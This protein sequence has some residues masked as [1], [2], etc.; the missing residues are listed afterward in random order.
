MKIKDFGLAKGDWIVHP[1]HGVGKVR[2]L[3]QKT[4]DGEPQPYLRVEGSKY[5]WWIAIDQIDENPIRPLRKPSTFKRALR[6]LKEEP[7]ALPLDA[8]ERRKL[9]RETLNTGS[10]AALCKVVRDLTA[11]SRTKRLPDEDRRRLDK[12]RSMLLHEWRLTLGIAKGEAEALLDE[13]LAEGQE[14][15]E[16]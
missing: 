6:L 1:K 12:Y 3:E 14:D 5:D 4:L 9:M 7:E 11:L 2:R 10:P 15:E 16:E 8:R 13:Y